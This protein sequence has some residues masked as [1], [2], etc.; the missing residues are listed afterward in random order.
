MQPHHFVILA[1]VLIA[2]YLAG[3]R[4]PVLAHKVGIA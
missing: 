4:W 2:G 3:A 1:L